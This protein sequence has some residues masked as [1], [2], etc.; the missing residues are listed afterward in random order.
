MRTTDLLRP[1]SAVS[2]AL[3]VATAAVG[4]TTS[5]DDSVSSN[6]WEFKLAPLYIW[7]AGIDGDVGLG[8][9]SAPVNITFGDVL[10][11]LSGIFTLHFE[12]RKSKW[13]IFADGMHLKI[14]PGTTLPNGAPVDVTVKNDIVEIG[15][16]YRIWDEAPS[17]ELLAGARY[18]H[19]DVSGL[20]GPLTDVNANW[21]DGFGGLRLAHAFGAKKNWTVSGRADA[22]AGGSDLTW[23]AIALVGWQFN[24][25]GALNAGYKWLDY[26]YETGSGLSRF[27]WDVTYEGPI[28]GLVFRW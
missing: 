24:K 1:L 9:I 13:N 10:D 18:T 19:L 4:Q 16:T 22:G 3:L 8:P 15:G 23:S 26:D 27:N 21:W 2:L 14:T 6:D 7:F 25:W 11:N 12:A 17:V 20:P 5:E 28:A